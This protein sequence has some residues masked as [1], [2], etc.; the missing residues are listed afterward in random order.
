M[1]MMVL[2]VAVMCLKSRY[3][4]QDVR[5]RTDETT[6]LEFINRRNKQEESAYFVASTSRHPGAAMACQ[7]LLNYGADDRDNSPCCVSVI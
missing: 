2:N 5:K 7:M 4:T 6:M 3:R 1:T